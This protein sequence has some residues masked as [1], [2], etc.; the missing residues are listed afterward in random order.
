MAQDEK[1]IIRSLIDPRIF[2]D[3]LALNDVF[4]GTSDNIPPERRGQATGHQ[5][6]N[7]LG[8]DYPLVSINS[9][10][11]KLEEIAN[12]T[13]DC[14]LFTPRLFLQ[15]DMLTTAA[16]TTQSMPKDGDLV[17]IFIRAKNDVFKPIRN[18]YVITSVDI[19]KGG[20][21]GMG[22]RVTIVGDLWI[23]NIRDEVVRSYNGT[24][25]EVLKQ[26]C[27][28]LKLGFASNETST[29]DTQN[30]VCAGDD[31]YS[32]INHIVDHSWKT[33][34]DFYKAYIDVYYHLNFVNVNNQFEGQGD[35]AAALLDSTLFKTYFSDDIGKGA[36]NQTEI[37]KMLTNL[38][39]FQN[40]NFFVKQYQ[41]KNN[42]SKVAEQFGY[43]T[44][45]Q[46]FDLKSLKYWDL[47]VDPLTS[48]GSEQ[49]KII[50]KGR[51]FPKQGGS[52]EPGAA[53]QEEFWKTQN[54]KV[55]LGVQSKNVHDNYLFS[56]IHNRRNRA[57]LEKL[58]VEVDIPRWNP[59]VYNGERL[60]MVLLNLTD[61][62]KKGVDAIGESA[63]QPPNSDVPSI[64]QFYTGYYVT[65]GM[66]FVFE[67]IGPGGEFS[68]AEKPE[69]PKPDFRQTL[70]LRR[71]EWPAP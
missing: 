2:L 50:L 41:I 64:D 37:P 31:Y 40:T 45:A 22:A 39:N 57:E 4:L 42:S 66:K 27:K 13:I 46:F 32:F 55:W 71:R 48:E 67:R 35:L 18:D 17:N 30:W 43:K 53:S 21:E 6:Q 51:T 5:E 60:P 3:E 16:F 25:I 8:T 12:F 19:G 65:D 62:L 54:K 52:T 9:Y 26:V 7:S 29:N 28:D 59:N 61:S 58:F 10:V 36:E 11:L 68:N 1:T 47:Y 44:H 15:F 38:E 20:I 63:D 24:S 34:R 14:T 33:P 69:F 23:P 49:N 70:T 56:E